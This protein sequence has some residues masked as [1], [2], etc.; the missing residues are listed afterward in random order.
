MKLDS[1]QVKLMIIEQLKTLPVCKPNS[2]KRNWVVRCPYCGDSKTASHGHFSIMIDVNSDSPMLYRCLKCNESGVLTSNV[3]ED[4]HLF[5]SNDLERNMSLLSRQSRNSS[6]YRD[7]PKNYTVPISLDREW[8]KNKL[9][10]LS[11]RL[12]TSL[13]YEE[14]AEYKI[15]LSFAEFLRANKLKIGFDEGQVPIKMKTLEELNDHYVGFLSS[16]N[17]KIIFRDYTEDQSGFF[18]RYYKVVID[19]L[20][21]SPNTFYGLKNQFDLLYHEPIN[22][23]IAEGTFDILSV[24]KNLPHEESINSLF[25]ASCGYGFSVILRYLI[26]MGVTTDI[27]LHIYSDNDKTDTEHVRELRKKNLNHWL[28]SIIIHRNNKSGEKDFGV[29]KDRIEDFSYVLKNV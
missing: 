17:N 12:G 8:N 20:N 1:A 11:K 19:P 2:I 10:Y 24:Y 3:L 28:S 25:F 21:T 7:K 16:N 13:T 9:D 23:H 15:I 4:L 27:V 26:Y 5:V 22:V 29:P 14:C 6:Y 18:G